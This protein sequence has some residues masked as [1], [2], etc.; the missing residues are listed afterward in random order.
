M[1]RLNFYENFKTF[2]LANFLLPYSLVYSLT[3]SLM[4]SVKRSRKLATATA[5]L[6]WRKCLEFRGKKTFH[7]IICLC[8]C[9]V[10]S[11]TVLALILLCGGHCFSV[12]QP[13]E[14]TRGFTHRIRLLASCNNVPQC[15]ITMFPDS[16][17]AA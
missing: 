8:M 2:Y 17:I 4:C 3:R 13:S 9:T 7:N 15:I 1:L 12:R 5:S 16:T 11:H 14:V 6:L 10:C